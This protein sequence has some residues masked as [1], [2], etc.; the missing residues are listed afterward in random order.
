MRRLAAEGQKETK[1]RIIGG[2]GERIETATF[3]VQ[4]QL[5]EDPS[6]EDIF[7]VRFRDS[8]LTE[9]VV[10]H[11]LEGYL[12]VESWS[13]ISYGETIPHVAIIKQDSGQLFE[14]GFDEEATPRRG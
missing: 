3:E 8:D 13:L 2:D 6:T 4:T 11:D 14:L 9:E 7:T 10:Y 1:L 5:D 12:K